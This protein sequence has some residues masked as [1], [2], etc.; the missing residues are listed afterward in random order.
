MKPA[1]PAQ[2]AQS[3]IEPPVSD[4]PV[5]SI[6]SLALQLYPELRVLARARMRRER[7]DH[8]L[9]ATALVNELYLR[10]LKAPEKQWVDRNHFLQAASRAM[11][12]LLI[13]HARA[14]KSQKGGGA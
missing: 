10:L 8:T 12:N 1:S 9:Q 13:D 2:P 7:V 11:H 4:V 14:K 5:G 6:E 3:V